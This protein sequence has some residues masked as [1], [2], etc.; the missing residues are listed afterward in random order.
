M[1]SQIFS[2]ALRTAQSIILGES[3]H[4][5]ATFESGERQKKKIKCISN[6]S[7]HNNDKKSYYLLKALHVSLILFNLHNFHSHEYHTNVRQK[8]R[9]EGNSLGN[10]N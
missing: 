6:G 5:R 2:S 7:I 4:V 10:C 3:L 9:E 1:H 8:D